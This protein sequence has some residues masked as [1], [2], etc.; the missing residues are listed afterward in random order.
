M[1]SVQH[2]IMKFL[3]VLEVEISLDRSEN[4]LKIMSLSQS[5]AEILM[6]NNENFVKIDQSYSPSPYYGTYLG[7]W[8]ILFMA[9]IKEKTV[10]T[11]KV[12]HVFFYDA[13]MT[14]INLKR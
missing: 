6:K 11:K 14:L 5:G 2:K 7:F 1:I 13:Q 3:S 12:S 4:T 10:D 9:Y 8:M